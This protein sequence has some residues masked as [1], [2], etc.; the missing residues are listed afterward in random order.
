M[1]PKLFQKTTKSRPTSDLYFSEHS[2]IPIPPQNSLSMNPT[3]Q[4]APT[5]KVRLAAVEQAIIDSK[6]REIETK[7]QLTTLLTSFQ[8]LELLLQNIQP[9]STSPKCPQLMLLP[10]D[11]SQSDN[12]HLWH[13]QASMMETDPEGTSCQTYIC[14]CPDSFPEEQTK[15]TWALSYMKSG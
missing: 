13:Y 4:H 12:L 8:Q 2:S 11:L 5:P 9:P 1:V 6:A 10:S 3:H 14:L 15:I 7:A